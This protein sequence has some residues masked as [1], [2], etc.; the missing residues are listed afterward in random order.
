[1]AVDRVLFALNGDH[2]DGS[3][4]G[5]GGDSDDSVE[6]MS[7]VDDEP[8][9]SMTLVQ[10]QAEFRREDLIHKGSHVAGSSLKKGRLEC[11]KSSS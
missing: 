10:Y 3:D 4:A 7:D 2:S 9:D 8:D 11:G 1:M 6:D 5:D